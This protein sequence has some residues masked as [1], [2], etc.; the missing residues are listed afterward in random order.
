MRRALKDGQVFG[1]QEIQKE[2]DAL[3]AQ[4]RESESLAAHVA[5]TK[6]KI[7]DAAA[8]L[9]ELGKALDKGMTDEVK[10]QLVETFLDGKIL[11]ETVGEGVK[12]RAVAHVKYRFN[13]PAVRVV[14]RTSGN[15]CSGRALHA[16]EAPPRLVPPHSSDPCFAWLQWIARPERTR[17]SDRGRYLNVS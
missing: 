8:L 2:A 10:R 16:R 9:T 3:S 14:T 11:V 6:A 17:P 5:T 12:R 7:E 4:V 1:G 15:G 13:R